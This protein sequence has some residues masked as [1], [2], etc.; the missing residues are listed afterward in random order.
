MSIPAIAY[1]IHGDDVHV[2]LRQT[3]GAAVAVVPQSDLKRFAW[4]IL[5][6]IAPDDVIAHNDDIRAVQGKRRP[7]AEAAERAP[8]VLADRPYDDA[9]DAQLRLLMKERG[10]SG[11]EAGAV[12]GRSRSSCIGRKARLKKAGLW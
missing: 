12:M 8:R 3:H 5:N 11:A 2:V 7:R 4:G 9:A 10:M 6:D 1:R